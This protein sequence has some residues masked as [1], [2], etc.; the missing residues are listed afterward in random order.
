[1]DY[2]NE[3]NVSARQADGKSNNFTEGKE[4]EVIVCVLFAEQLRAERLLSREEI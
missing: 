3:I 4:V 1:M 2:R